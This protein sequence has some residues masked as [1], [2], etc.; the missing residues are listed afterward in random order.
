MWNIDRLVKIGTTNLARDFGKDLVGIIVE[1]DRE[2]YHW[3]NLDCIEQGDMPFNFYIIAKSDFKG[4]DLDNEYMG[5]VL[6][7]GGRVLYY[8]RY[9]IGGGPFKVQDFK[10]PEFRRRAELIVHNIDQLLGYD[11]EP[12]FTKDPS[13]NSRQLPP[14]RL[15][16]P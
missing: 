10:N 6:V 3:V 7:R 11:G 2:P 4:Y 8:D 16:L 9:P 15:E 1:P 14:S 13:Q 5:K 12:A